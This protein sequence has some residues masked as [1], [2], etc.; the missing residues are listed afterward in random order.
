[1][2]SVEMQ[3]VPGHSKSKCIYWCRYREDKSVVL[4]ELFHVKDTLTALMGKKYF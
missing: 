1:M 2:I 3:R 4:F